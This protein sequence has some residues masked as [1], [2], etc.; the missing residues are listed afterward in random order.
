MPAHGAAVHRRLT[1]AIVAEAKRAR[2][3]PLLVLAVI[4]VESSFEPLAVS[5]AGAVGLMQLREPTMRGEV[6]QSRLPSAD[7]R[8]PVANVQA[9]VRYLRRLLDS[10]GDLDVALMAYNAG[11]ERIRRQLLRGELPER[12]RRYARRVNAEL[13]RLRGER[14][15]GS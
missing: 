8:D 9:G 4:H 7:R 2:L 12:Y 1:R 5:S 3:D 14:P 6:A 15:R 10:F 11:P 13:G